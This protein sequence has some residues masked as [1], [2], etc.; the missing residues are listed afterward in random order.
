MTMPSTMTRDIGPIDEAIFVARLNLGGDGPRVA[1]KDS[2]DIAGL[3]TRLASRAFA[4]APPAARHAAVVQR[5]LDAGCRLIGKTNMHELAYGVTGI[6]RFTGTPRN[7]L[8]AARIPGGSSSGSAVAVARG[9]ADF[10]LGTDTGGSIRI[11]AAC[12]GIMGLK[13]TYGRVSRDGVHPAESSLDCVGPFAL[14]VAGI[15][16]AMSL[17]DPTFT[18]APPPARRPRLGLVQ[19]TG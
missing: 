12:C 14:S 19:A 6:N 16:L 2:I 7:P 5:L 11:P 18:A 3:P 8:D 15:E 1:I 13:P 10:A 17:I 4:N 9:F